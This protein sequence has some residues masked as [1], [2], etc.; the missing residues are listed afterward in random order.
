MTRPR[1]PAGRAD[2]TTAS[3]SRDEG[4]GHVTINGGGPVRGDAPLGGWKQSGIGRENGEAG[5]REF[6]EPV[7]VQ[8]PAEG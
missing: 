5:V 1:P 3:T 7:T 4:S 2:A 8:W 6:L